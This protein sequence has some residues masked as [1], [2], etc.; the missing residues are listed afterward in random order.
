MPK[1]KPKLS[2]GQ[3]QRPS[4]VRKAEEL[5]SAGTPLPPV[6]ALRKKP[7]LDLCREAGW[8][9]QHLGQDFNSSQELLDLLIKELVACR[10]AG[11]LDLALALCDAAEAKGVV[12]P[13]IT[14]NRERVKRAQRKIEP[15][16]L[17]SPDG[18]SDGKRGAS[19]SQS[20]TRR[21]KAKAAKRRPLS[22]WQRLKFALGFKSRVSRAKTGN[23]GRSECQNPSVQISKEPIETTSESISALEAL[24]KVCLQAGWAPQCLQA[25]DQNDVALAC[26]QEMQ[27]CRQAGQHALVVG[28]ATQAAVLGL[29]HPRIQDNL[30]RS[31]GKA[32]RANV[33]S[34]AQNLLQASPPAYQ[35]SAS[36]LADALL[37]EPDCSSYRKLLVDTVRREIEERSGS[38]LAPELRDATVDLQVNERLLEALERRRNSA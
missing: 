28:L 32:A 13:R 6:T 8:P 10:E 20:P 12:H 25:S 18:D 21:T 11:K 33:L 9:P 22:V 5:S 16:A 35:A 4:R 2:R 31:R 37:A 36:L 27:R 29:E 38:A 24:R 23:Q 19:G 7:L 3:S 30:Q 34:Q 15:L 1:S 14:G 17:I 26:A